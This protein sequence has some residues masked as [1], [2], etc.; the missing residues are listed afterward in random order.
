MEHERCA[1]K[2]TR[3]ELSFSAPALRSL[4]L[5]GREIPD[6]C[7]A[8]TLCLFFEQSDNVVKLSG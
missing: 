4:R 5:S 2:G 6:N 1:R 8:E 3:A 7:T